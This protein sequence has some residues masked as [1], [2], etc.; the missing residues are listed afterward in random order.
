MP[1]PE[2]LVEQIHADLCY[3]MRTASRAEEQQ[4]TKTLADI[5]EVLALA[6]AQLS[7]RVVMV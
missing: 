1:H 6:M 7:S 5:Q 4:D 3:L 2:D